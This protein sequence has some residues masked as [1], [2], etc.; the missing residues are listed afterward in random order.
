MCSNF[1]FFIEI[2][3]TNLYIHLN[4]LDRKLKL[5]KFFSIHGK[6]ISMKKLKYIKRKVSLN[7]HTN[8]K[9]LVYYSMINECNKIWSF[10]K[11][12]HSIVMSHI[13]K[14]NI[15]TFNFFQWKFF[16]NLLQYYN[17]V[18]RS[19]LML[20]N[21]WKYS[22]RLFDSGC[23]FQNNIIKFFNAIFEPMTSNLHSVL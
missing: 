13:T 6:G 1:Q 7:I 9:V 16:A 12:G 17:G 11:K 4:R 2:V 22:I 19:I 23:W 3:W 15:C 10:P 14:S 8:I 18:T 20:L 5:L 21:S